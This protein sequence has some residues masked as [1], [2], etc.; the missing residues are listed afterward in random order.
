MNIRNMVR[1]AAGVALIAVSP[2]IA[3]T[4]K[5][6]PRYGS[7]GV[8]LTAQ[9]PSV[10]PGDDFWMYA[11]GGWN[12]RVEIAADRASAGFGTQLSIEAE[13]NVRAILDDMA[14]NPAAY[15]AGGKQVGDFYASWM[16]EAGIEKAGTAPLK[17]YL[18][19]IDGVK[20]LD[21]LQVLFATTGYASPVELGIIP[22]LADPTHYTAVTG[23]GGLGMPR[24]YY[25]L[26]GAKYDAFRTAYRA[27]V[28]KIQELAGIPNAAAKADAIIALETAMAKVQWS[29]A[30]SRDIAKL[31][32]PQ[33][34]AGL[35][36][37]APDFNWALMLK[38]AGLESSPSVLMTQ[39]T[40]VTA[41]GKLMTATPLA[42]WKDYLAYRF[43]SDHAQ[44]LPKVFDDTRFGF[45]SQTLSGVKVQR[46]RWKRG[47][48]LV[49]GALGEAVGA[50]YVAKYFPPAAEK[51]MAELI[52]NLRG[53]YKDRITA[54]TWMDDATKQ[55]ALA[56]LAAFEPRI[57]HPDKYIDYSSFKVVR[58][59]L[60][61]NAMRSGEFQHELEL[62]RFGK[63]VD[64]TLWDMTPQTVNAYYNPL[65]NQI[66][67]P[68]AILQP[69]FFDPNAD[70]AVNYGAIGA[71]IGHEMG[72]GFDDQGSQFGPTGKFENWWTDSAKKAFG[73]R[74]AALVAQYDGYEAVPGTKVQ[75]K[76]TLG[77]NIGDLGGVE[78][79]YG[80]F[81]KYQAEHGKA[82]V[83]GGLT[84]DQRFFLSYAQAWQ[85]K[86]REDTARQYALIDP[87]SPAMFR[88]NGIVRNVD[89]W[90]KA[91]NIQPGDK[92]YLA[93]E[94]R[95][96]IW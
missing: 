20:N 44:F 48:Q 35:K 14:K 16:D 95:V 25:L 34:Q 11:N 39:N 67:F 62:S 59:D 78:A 33:T 76:L 51:Q 63:P 9:K 23:Q 61:G 64:R 55:K 3:Q 86:L 60:L 10:K 42:T 49:N 38:T 47:I 66:T 29:P 72:H 8:D 82:P 92:L 4:A 17:P 81:Q 18:A 93:P 87:H 65:S 70:P 19:K 36:A 75:G 46:E 2:A 91:F 77:E 96:H 7:F 53:A 1:L 24:D 43:V 56:K 26:E 74:T 45:Y 54:S 69:P 90:Y 89:A 79:A 30:E 12:D 80:A 32:D 13:A 57:G 52:E 5:P 84:G 31:N 6:A 40:A 71:I 73:E 28:Q 83:I 88:V 15:G 68:A 94:Q 37:K 58:G 85:T 41:L 50:I 27:Y 21:A 22:D